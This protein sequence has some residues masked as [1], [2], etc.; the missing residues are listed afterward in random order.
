MG[1]RAISPV[2]TVSCHRF[3]KTSAIT[4]SDSKPERPPDNVIKKCSA[5]TFRN[6]DN[7]NFCEPCNIGWIQSEDNTMATSCTQCR[8][9]GEK[10]A[11]ETGQ[12]TCRDCPAH[13]QKKQPEPHESGEADS[14][15]VCDCQAGAHRLSHLIPMREC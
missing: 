11:N 1:Q 3:K 9:L 8:F 6:I 7:N 5:G 12:F 4:W 14:I 2:D 15:L 10:Y 13:T